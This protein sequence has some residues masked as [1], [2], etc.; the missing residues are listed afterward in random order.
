[1]PEKVVKTTMEPYTPEALITMPI[2]GM[3]GRMI[4]NKSGE[5]SYEL[6]WY[7]NRFGWMNRERARD[8]Y[9]SKLES[10]LEK[11]HFPSVL[12]WP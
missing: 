12:W 1:M 6:V 4:E 8:I 5:K 9:N 7:H 11:L 10:Y 3:E 2:H